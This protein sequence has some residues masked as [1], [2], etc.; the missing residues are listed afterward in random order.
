MKARFA[1]QF[2]LAVWGL[3]S[4]SARAACLNTDNT[5]AYFCVTSLAAAYNVPGGGG[6]PTISL[7]M[8]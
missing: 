2:L 1:L 5:P 4:V 7:M 3:G 8:H 6:T